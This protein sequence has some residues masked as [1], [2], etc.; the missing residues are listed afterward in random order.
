MHN[1]SDIDQTI[2]AAGF[3]KAKADVSTNMFS[4]G[5]RAESTLKAGNVNIVPHVGA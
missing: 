2:N 1:S 4:L 5:V 3:N